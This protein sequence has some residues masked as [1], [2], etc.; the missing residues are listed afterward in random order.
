MA[1]NLISIRQLAKNG[2]RTLFYDDVAEISDKN[3]RV[4]VEA[5][6]REELYKVQG[7][8]TNDEEA[9]MGRVVDE[10]REGEITLITRVQN[11][12]G[13]LNLW[14]RRLGHL[15][16]DDVL[17]M[18]KKGM[19]EGMQIIPQS[20][21]KK[22]ICEA[23]LKGKQTREPIPKE[24]DTRATEILHRIHSDLCDAGESREGYRYYVTFIDDY[25]RYTEVI[26]LKRKDETLEAFKKF[27]A[28]AENE[29]GKRIIR[30]RSDGGGEFYSKEFIEYCN[31]KGIAQEKTNP[32]TPQ[33]NGVA[34]RKNQTLNNKA[35]S[36]LAE[37]NLTTTF[38]ASAIQ[39]ANWITN[40]SPTRAL[41][42][43]KTPYELYYNKKPSI[44]ALRVFGCKV[45]VQIPKKHRAK[46]DNRT[47]ECVFLG[48]TS[49]KRAFIAFDRK[50]RRVIESR[51]V[52]FE[53]GPE[54][55]RIVIRDEDD[56]EDWTE[57]RTLTDKEVEEGNSDEPDGSGGEIDTV[58]H[59]VASPTEEN[60]ENPET[61]PPPPLRRSTRIRRPPTPDDA[62]KYFV[63]SR[64]KLTEP[65]PPVNQSNED[66]TEITDHAAL[67]STLEPQ[68]YRDAMQREDASNW[69]DAMAKEMESQ[70]KAETYIE[71]PKPNDVNILE[72]RWVYAYKFGAENQNLI[73][74]ARLVA[75]GFKQRPGE[76]FNETF[77]PTM[78]KS[79]LL[80]LLAIAAQEDLEV[81]HLDIKTAFL[82]G[83]LEEEIYMQPPEGFP[84]KEAGNVWK[85]KKS[86]Y[87][88]KQAARMWYKKFKSSLDE[89]GFQRTNSDHAVFTRRTGGFA[90]VAFH[91]DDTLIIT[92]DEAMKSRVKEEISHHFETKDLGK[93]KLFCGFEITRDRS[94][95]TITVGQERYNKIILER[96]GLENARP[97][98]TP[99]AINLQLE[100]QENATID[101]HLYQSM[102]GSLMYAAVGT[103]PDISFAVNTLAQH[104]SAPGEEHLRALKRIFQYLIG[105]KSYKLVFNGRTKDRTLIGF[106]DAD[107]AGDVNS[108]RSISGYVFFLNGTPISWTA[109][110]QPSI[111]LSS[112]ESEYMASSHATREAVYLR[113]FLTEIGFRQNIPT[114]ILVDNQSAIA[115][116]RNPEFHARTKHIEVR[117]HYVREKLEEGIIE[118]QYCPTADQTADILTKSLPAV[119]HL[120]F[121]KNL[122]FL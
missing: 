38:W 9:C 39:Y 27:V 35:R 116:A 20:I 69:M 68:S 87:G 106:V 85:L 57:N 11:S 24:T 111:S 30:F 13:T 117:H 5:K 90:C 55:E 34:E 81:D 37:A 72:S 54:R 118:L 101:V 12:T 99:M 66:N 56:D 80:T 36:M 103:R 65:A 115:L 121:V 21:Q 119:K 26:P 63:D 77:A 46:F 75:K 86:I 104:A 97:V 41:D 15:N 96:F 71:V 107:W 73:Y 67:M 109:K 48:F 10:N 59:R 31:G 61:S 88:L 98:T 52:K 43:N 79:S 92:R 4:K 94:A 33:Q 95:R 40:R 8:A 32:D 2:L 42:D 114:P 50:N 93:V 51:D 110:K 3:G 22:S 17:R 120:N 6:I 62:P 83:E 18:Y 122:T 105:T 49:G 74:K 58:N 89:M 82:N 84:P 108:R 14:H 19:V 60:P 91:V 102:L 76:D 1:G 53:E 113:Q 78:H 100:R 45:W 70:N 112:T 25:S 47:V 64:K 44:T 29:T 23:C 7:Y 16:E 28:R